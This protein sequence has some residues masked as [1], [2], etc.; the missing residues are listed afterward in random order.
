M[1]CRR[2]GCSSHAGGDRA[3]ADRRRASWCPAR[4]AGSWRRT[5]VAGGWTR[6]V[7]MRESRREPRVP[8]FWRHASLT[9]HVVAIAGKEDEAHGV[10]GAARTGRR[11]PAGRR[12]DS[13]RRQSLARRRPAGRLRRRPA[14][15]LR[16][17]PEKRRFAGR[18]WYRERRRPASRRWSPAMRRRCAALPEVGLLARRRP[19]AT[20][21]EKAGRPK[22]AYGDQGGGQ[23][24]GGGLWRRGVWPAA[25][26]GP[27]QGE[28]RLADKDRLR[29]LAGGGGGGGDSSGSGEAPE[30]R[31]GL[32]LATLNSLTM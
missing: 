1:C 18:K 17:L 10:R 2:E 23:P 22:V 9:H 19:A 3:A 20:G 26:D 32:V 25:G 31:H 8:G 7:A 6:V 13:H 12:P 5:E 30:N 24:T 15:H 14:S 27:R 4:L 28:G 29:R 21:E 16:F 11:R